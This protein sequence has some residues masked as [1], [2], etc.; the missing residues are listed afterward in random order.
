MLDVNAIRVPGSLNFWDRGH[1]GVKR[2]WGVD[3]QFR[4]VDYTV[5]I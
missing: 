5:G 4:I 3:L 2:N 1:L